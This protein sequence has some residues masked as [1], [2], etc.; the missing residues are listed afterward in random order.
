MEVLRLVA[1]GHRSRDV[2]DILCL[3]K[4]TVDSHLA[5]MFGKLGVHNRILAVRA[6]LRLSRKE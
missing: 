2:A 6:A 5:K 4:S 3:S 1:A